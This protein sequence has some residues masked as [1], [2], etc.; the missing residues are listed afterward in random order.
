MKNIGFVVLFMLI[1][2]LNAFSQGQWTYISE[3]DGQNIGYVSCMATGKDGSVWVGSY[4]CDGVLRYYNNQWHFESEKIRNHVNNIGV[5]PNGDIWFCVNPDSL[6]KFDGVNWFYY[7]VPGVIQFNDVGIDKNNIVWC[8]TDNG[9]YK[10][11]GQV[12][13]NYSIPEGLKSRFVSKLTLSPDGVPWIRYG[14]PYGFENIGVHGVSYFNG[15][16]WITFDTSSGLLF[17]DIDAI[18]FG[19]DGKVYI[20]NCRPIPQKMGI[21][22]LEDTEWIQISDKYIGPLVFDKYGT[23]WALYTWHL[24][25]QIVNYKDTFWN[26]MT[27][28]PRPTGAFI[29]RRLTIDDF[30]NVWLGTYL[31]VLVYSFNTNVNSENN[32]VPVEYTFLNNYPN[33]FNSSTTISYILHEPSHVK[34]VI[35][36]SIG[37]EVMKIADGYENSGM[38]NYMIN[39]SGLNSGQYFANLIVNGKK[40]TSK[41]MLLK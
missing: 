28:I 14:D 24:D 12:W 34:L 22:R 33:P 20:S 36:N 21:Y 39:F 9:V 30:D 1:A 6:V 16:E 5:A 19:P 32:S 13:I 25:Y 17:N 15:V 26:V 41:L 40:T 31:G 18:E 4:D 11:D 29:N 37:Q 38:K 8:A 35:Y 10:Y 23:L 2:G 3:A 27:E 7:S